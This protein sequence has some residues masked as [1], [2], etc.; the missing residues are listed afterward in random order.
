MNLFQYLTFWSHCAP[1]VL[2]ART[3]DKDPE[4]YDWCSLV[5]GMGHLH[6]NQQ[7]TLFKVLDDILLEPLGKDVLKFK[8]PNAYQF[9]ISAGDTHK[10]FQTIQVLLFGTVMELYCQ[11]KKETENS[12]ISVENFLCWQAS[13]PNP[14]IRLICQL[15]LNYTLAVF[16]FKIGIRHNDAKLI[17]CARFKF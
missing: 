2:T 8:S 1:Y 5:S 14:T 10:S 13:H 16:L 11:Y 3:I 12:I 7:K 6:M 4:K 17:N 15:M 9:F